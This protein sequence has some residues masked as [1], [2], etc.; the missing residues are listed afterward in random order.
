MVNLR[1]PRLFDP[2]LDC[3]VYNFVFHPHQ[4]LKRESL[5]CV[6]LVP[7]I[8]LEIGDQDEQELTLKQKVSV[9][10]LYRLL[11]VIDSLAHSIIGIRFTVHMQ[12]VIVWEK[13][14]QLTINILYPKW[15]TKPLI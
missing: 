12:L 3:C 14:V 5:E 4:L 1:R 7:L 8:C 15:L 6:V 13:M 11:L 9:H 2:V 10:V